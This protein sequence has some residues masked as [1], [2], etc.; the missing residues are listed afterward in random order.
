MEPQNTKF[1]FTEA[2]LRNLPP[3][4]MGER[5]SYHDANQRGLQLRVTASG[6][7]T[8]YVFKRIAGHAPT[9]VRVGG[10]PA[11]T[12]E[13][14]RARA[15]EIINEMESGDNPN[16]VRRAIRGEPTFGEFFRTYLEQHAKTHKLTWAEDLQRYNQYLLHPLSNKKLS[17]IT[18]QELGAIHAEITNSGHPVVANRVLA[19]ISC[20]FGRA[21]E[22]DVLKYNPAKGIRKNQEV[23]RDRFLSEIELTRFFK[24]L[25]HEPNETM[26]DFFLAALLTGARRSNLQEM[27]WDQIDLD[28]RTWRIP[29]TKNG[30]PQTVPLVDEMVALLLHRLEACDGAGFVFPGRS[31]KGHVTEPKIAWARVLERAGILNLRLHD[32]RRTMGSYQAKNGASLI[33]IGR[34]LNHMTPS[35]T[36]IYARVNQDPVQASMQAAVT[37]MLA[38][39][40]PTSQPVSASEATRGVQI[41]TALS[42]ISVTSFASYTWT[43]A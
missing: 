14:A 21:I 19:L 24:A 11:M 15:R 31:K 13:R 16:A 35:T 30:T 17:V 43:A 39:K 26:R 3:A 34:S 36:A 12:V 28:A 9:R 23:S 2:R 37:S 22:W 25:D 8:F 20:V 33:I 4:P 40:A 32:L 1:N 29:V 27:G 6:A 10:Y 18:R 41:K 42:S 38:A 7:K 5:I